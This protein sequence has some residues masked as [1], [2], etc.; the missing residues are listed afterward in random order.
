[1]EELKQILNDFKE[2]LKTTV[3][4]LLS[5]KRGA[6]RTIDEPYLWIYTVEVGAVNT[7][8]SF[9]F[10]L[11]TTHN[12]L[13][14]ITFSSEDAIVL[15]SIKTGKVG[16]QDIEFDRHPIFQRGVPL[17]LAIAEDV[18]PECK[19]FPLC[20]DKVKD[21]H[22]QGSIMLTDATLTYPVNVQIVHLLDNPDYTVSEE[23]C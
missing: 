17:R 1:M 13:M 7:S 9:D 16:D 5:L 15:N 18:C 21:K 8:V 19:F 14:G 3:L 6:T 10:P 22:I 11:P 23:R 4:T 20:Y 2:A 12:R